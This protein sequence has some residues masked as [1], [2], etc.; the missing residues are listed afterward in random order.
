MK[1]EKIFALVILGLIMISLVAVFVSAAEQATLRG[2]IVETLPTSIS[3]NNAVLAFLMFILSPQL[4]FGIL[5][6][7]VIFAVISRISLFRTNKIIGIVVSIVIS[8]LAAMFIHAPWIDVIINQYTALGITITFL[9]PFVL[10]FY[11]LLEIV[12]YNSLAQKVVWIVYLVV[13]IFNLL[14]HW[15]N[16]GGLETVLYIIVIALSL[17][18]IIFTRQVMDY[19]Q[20]QKMEDAARVRTKITT[21]KTAHRLKEER[22]AIIESGLPPAEIE[23][24]LADL[25]AREAAATNR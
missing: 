22:E 14:V 7:L 11:F 24:M 15:K 5:I 1:K 17:A 23:T 13:V 20:K 18:L 19:V 9:I 3:N 16:L 6:F 4:L 25:D 21:L 8:L 12:P 10:L 2:W